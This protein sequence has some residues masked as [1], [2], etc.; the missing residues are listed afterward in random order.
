MYITATQLKQDTHLL[1]HVSDE[2][3]II[4]KRSHPFAVVVEYE[5]YQELTR[6]LEQKKIQTKLDALESLGSFN[7]G[8]K[9]YKQIKSEVKI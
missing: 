6:S 3:I 7:L 2:D 5:R 1:S 8:G 4:T 9:S